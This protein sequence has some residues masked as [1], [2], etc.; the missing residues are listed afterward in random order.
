MKAYI[1][2]ITEERQLKGADLVGDYPPHLET[3]H[4][5]SVWAAES[6]AEKAFAKFF[7]SA[8]PSIETTLYD[9]VYRLIREQEYKLAI[10]LTNKYSIANVPKYSHSGYTRIVIEIIP[11]EFLGSPF[12]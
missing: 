8:E 3:K 4:H 5:Y 11:S 12:D 10:N 7:K 1:L 2:H 6:Q 9:V